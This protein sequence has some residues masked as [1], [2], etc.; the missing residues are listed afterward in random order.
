MKNLIKISFDEL[1]ENQVLRSC[2]AKT[3]KPDARRVNIL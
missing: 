3:Q 2:F 1:S